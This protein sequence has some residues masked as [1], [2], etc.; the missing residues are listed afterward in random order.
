VKGLRLA[1]ARSGAALRDDCRLAAILVLAFSKPKRCRLAGAAIDIGDLT[2]RGAHALTI[3]DAQVRVETVADAR[4]DRPWAPKSR[5]AAPPPGWG[6]DD[7]RPRRWRR[8]W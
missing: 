3:E 5:A 2:A 1:V 6:D 8:R 7:Y 4:G